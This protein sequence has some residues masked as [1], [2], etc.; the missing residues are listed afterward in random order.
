MTSCNMGLILTRKSW[1]TINSDS[2][3]G[4]GE[5]EDNKDSQ[6]HYAHRRR[7]PA[8]IRSGLGKLRSTKQLSVQRYGTALLVRLRRIVR[9]EPGAIEDPDDDLEDEL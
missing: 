4:S 6:N 5:K 1:S 8:F 7:A 3:F 2:D 9:N